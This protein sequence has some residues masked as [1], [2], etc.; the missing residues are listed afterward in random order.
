MTILLKHVKPLTPDSIAIITPYKEQ[1]TRTRE[2]IHDNLT[3]M[4]EVNTVDAFQ[5]QEKDIIIFSCVRSRDFGGEKKG[6]GFLKDTRRLNV[7]LTRAKYAL[8]TIGSSD[9]LST[10]PV[11]SNYLHHMN[12]ESKY[13]QMRD[14]DEALEVLNKLPSH[15]KIK[16]DLLPNIKRH[17]QPADSDTH[18]LGKR[19]ANRDDKNVNRNSRKMDL[20]ELSNLDRSGLKQSSQMDTE[21]P[22]E[23]VNTTVVSISSIQK[24]SKKEK[25]RMNE[26]ETRIQIKE[27]PD[28]KTREDSGPKTLKDLV[29]GPKPLN[30]KSSQ[31]FGEVFNLARELRNFDFDQNLHDC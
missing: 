10:N 9:V 26:E 29:K 24:V 31:D 8:Y 25:S 5:G 16:G 19:F 3:E 11:W 12:S 28:N 7:A 6:I 23:S 27:M 22:L 17:T 21:F 2:M 13:K 15:S 30:K 4:I 18:L 20:E 1:M 14:M